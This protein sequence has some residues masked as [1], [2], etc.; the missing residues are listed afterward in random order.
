VESLPDV[1]RIKTFTKDYY[2]E[3]P[4]DGKDGGPGMLGLLHASLN[5]TNSTSVKPALDD[6]D[7]TTF[8]RGGY[9]LREVHGDRVVILCLNTVLY[10]SNFLPRP[11]HAEDPGG[12]FVFL[13]KVLARCRKEGKKA[14]LMGHIPPSLGSFRHSQLWN[15]MYIQK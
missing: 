5:T 8:L 15:E 3:L 10:S 11:E 7:R 9:Y 13:E 12:Q 14:I 4:E 1:C 6:S 2:L